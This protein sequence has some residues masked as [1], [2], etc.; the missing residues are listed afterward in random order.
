VER[1][2]YLERA[3]ASLCQHVW[4]GELEVEWCVSTESEGC[5]PEAERLQEAACQ[6]FGFEL[7][8]HAGRP[9][10]GRHLSDTLLR[11]R[12]WEALFYTQEDWLARAH[13]PL[14]EAVELM[15]RREDVVM[16]RL[17]MS[18]HQSDTVPLEDG[19][20]ELLPSSEWFFAHN[21]Y[22]ARREFIEAMLPFPDREGE[23][24]QKAKGLVRERGWRF[25][26][27][28]PEY[29]FE[30]IGEVPAMTEKH[31]ARA[32]ARRAGI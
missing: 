15:E 12:E 7:L 14:A 25:A 5:E 27:L 13:V 6:R 17:L 18:R 1:A 21:P 20:V 2:Q 32:A 26:T 30:H 22:V 8:Y 16:V 31:A 3:L 9:S 4:A 10:L 28:L 29:P 24:N 11:E 19:F 23:V